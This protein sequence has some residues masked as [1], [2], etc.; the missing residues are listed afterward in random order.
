[1]KIEVVR[2]AKHRSRNR[3]TIKSE[4][5]RKV[6]W[7]ADTS[8]ETSKLSLRKQ[9]LITLVNQ[10]ADYNRERAVRYAR[11]MLHHQA[12]GTGTPAPCS[13]RYEF[14]ELNLA[15][16]VLPLLE[17]DDLEQGDQTVVLFSTAELDATFKGKTALKGK[18][19]L[20]ASTG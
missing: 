19:T 11:I 20:K 6:M 16:K 8:I 1:M 14:A 10:I 4:E 2:P 5:L 17:K 15:L 12:Q 9:A 7:E 18:K 3:V 13:G